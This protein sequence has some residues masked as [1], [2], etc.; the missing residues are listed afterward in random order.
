MKIVVK[1]KKYKKMK[2]KINTHV[3]MIVKI[4]VK[5]EIKIQINKSEISR[6]SLGIEKLRN[7]NLMMKRD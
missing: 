7:C 5:I 3:K 2:E 4:K 1:I 6:F